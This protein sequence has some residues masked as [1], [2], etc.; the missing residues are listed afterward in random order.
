[1]KLHSISK[2]QKSLF[3]TKKAAAV[4]PLDT[5]VL[6]SDS[7]EIV[8]A[9]LSPLL[10]M[11]S[12]FN[13]ECSLLFDKL[14]K[15]FGFYVGSVKLYHKLSAKKIKVCFPSFS[16]QTNLSFKGLTDIGL[17][18][19]SNAP[20]D[21]EG[22]TFSF[23]N[24]SLVI[25]TG[26]NQ[27]GKTTFLRS[28]GLAQLL[29]QCGL[30]V[31][32]DAFTCNLFQGI[33]THFPNEEDKTL[34]KGLLEQELH[35]LDGLVNHMQ[36][37]SLLLMNETFSTTSEYDASILAEQILSAFVKCK[38][39]TF[40]VTHLYEY[41]HKLYQSQ[42]EHCI[43]LRAVS[44]PGSGVTYQLKEGEPLRSGL[45]IELYHQVID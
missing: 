11:L 10:K 14:L 45:A 17:V 15:M 31:S 20:A 32:A 40:F 1:M 24:K 22:N 9:G 21:I 37:G 38:V 5:I 3:R 2:P 27:G 23:S 8:D 36:P 43:F 26:R 16:D 13:Q 29:S 41:A 35:G 39:T 19:K 7:Q 44:S 30:F 6:I 42:P 25:I 4:I 18:L 34:N 12:R 28:V 33:Y